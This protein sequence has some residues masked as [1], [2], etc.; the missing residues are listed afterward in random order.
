MTCV[1]V[2][3]MSHGNCTSLHICNFGRNS[4]GVGVTELEMTSL[5]NFYKIDVNVIYM[6]CS[7]HLV[8]KPR[9]CSCR[10][11]SGLP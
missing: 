9:N 4:V 1:K 5:L 8:V 7:R 2:L 3:V 10:A 11:L 6:S